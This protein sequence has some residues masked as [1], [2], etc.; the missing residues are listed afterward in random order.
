MSQPLGGPGVGLPL[1]QYLYPSELG[2]APYDYASNY[3]G[4]AAG[5]SIPI[6]AGVW[7]VY[8]GKVSIV[9]F[10][11]P[12]TTSWR[13]LYAQRGQSQ[14]IKSDGFNFRLA[15]LTGCPVG[16]VVTNAGS[17]YVEST[18]TV[19]PSVGNS[20]WQAI[21]G[22]MVSIVSVTVVGAGYGMPPL[23]FIPAPPAPGVQATAYATIANGTVSG[24]TMTNVGA[25]YD[26]APTVVIYPNPYD[27]NL[28]AGITQATCTTGLLGSGSIAAIICTNP[29]VSVSSV[30]TLTIAGAGSSAAATAIRLTTMVSASVVAGQGGAYAAGA[31]GITAGGVPT[32]TAVNTNPEIE[33]FNF[34]PRP[35]SFLMA[36]TSSLTSVS[37]IYDSGLFLNTPAAAISPINSSPAT[38]ASVT[39]NL[40]GITDLVALQPAC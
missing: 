4:L 31:T 17:A 10:L 23:V 34:I 29:G 7:Q 39:I 8:P 2:S 1:P 40:G 25:G 14:R 18:T 30:P 22:G 26:S 16:A 13:G 6:P 3:L 28:N 27:P 24:V 11:D 37:T 33:G 15:N 36:G 32:A 12:V 35:A 38:V 5:D 19:T 20:T 21:V 9:Q